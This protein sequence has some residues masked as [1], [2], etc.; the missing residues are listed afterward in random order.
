MVKQIY[1]R[2]LALLGPAVIVDHFA[3]SGACRLCFV[4]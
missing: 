3:G 2:L 4:F 1:G